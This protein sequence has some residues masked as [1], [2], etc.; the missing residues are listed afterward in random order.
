MRRLLPIMI[1]SLLVLSAVSLY[2][3]VSAQNV[4]GEKRWIKF[5]TGVITVVVPSRHVTP[6]Y[7]WWYDKAPKK[8]YVAHYY[9]LA[10]VWLPHAMKF[11]HRYMFN[12]SQDLS[13]QIMG[14]FRGESAEEIGRMMDV[15]RRVEESVRMM[16]PPF[17]PFALCNWSL[18]GPLNIT[19]SAGNVIG[20]EFSF[21]LEGRP[22]HMSFPWSMMRWS[23]LGKGDII[24]RNRIY[25][26]PVNE[27]VGNQTYTV[28]R[29]ELK[30]DIVIK[31]WM[32]NYDILNKS[33][34]NLTKFIP[35]LKP[36]L[37][38][39]SRFTLG[40]YRHEE[41][42]DI[43]KGMCFGSGFSMSGDVE[44]EH[45]RFRISMSRTVNR[46]FEFDMNRSGFM[47]FPELVIKSTNST[48]AGF[49]RFIPYASVKYNN[50]V[51]K[52]NVSGV[53][54]VTDRR[55][56][57]FLVYP[58]FN[59]GSLEHDPSIGVETGASESPEYTVTIENGLPKQVES[60]E[61]TTQVNNQTSTTQ[62]S[63]SNVQ[64]SHGGE[65]IGGKNLM[66][67]TWLL[68]LVSVLV[69]ILVLGVILVRRR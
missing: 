69:I 4:E 15:M 34:G 8:I 63:Q 2:T 30:N 9:G 50:T 19:D 53:F 66:H 62:G 48:I 39:I 6:I 28:T 43:M 18:E 42:D 12:K 60:L 64:P 51:E 24:I 58:Y 14:R 27:T 25:Y 46:E 22:R 31:H 49:Y 23:F 45:G 54:L 47:S 7:F 20:V 32:W 65:V 56:M 35:K 57:V 10:E 3:N 61:S 67:N 13:R 40:N 16:H 11:R 59:N 21:I 44:V 37:I 68:I 33:L 29:A 55:L 26:V 17:L 1:I 52:V 36:K 41:F 38:L 5:D